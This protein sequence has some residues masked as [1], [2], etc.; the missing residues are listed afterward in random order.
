MEAIF[1]SETLGSVELQCAVTQLKVIFKVTAV[2]FSNPTSKKVLKSYALKDT[3]L[4]T[5]SLFQ[6]E[7]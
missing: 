3:H 6:A 2:R 1:S 4:S 7:L 5:T